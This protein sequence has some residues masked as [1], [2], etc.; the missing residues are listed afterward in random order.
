MRALP[1]WMAYLDTAAEA[2]FGALR[3]VDPTL[4]ELAAYD[5]CGRAGPALTSLPAPTHWK[6]LGLGEAH[7]GHTVG[8][9]LPEEAG[10]DLLA[11]ADSGSGSGG[12]GIATGSTGSTTGSV[13][14]TGAGANTTVTHRLSNGVHMPVLGL[15]TWQLDG[16]ACEEAV[17]E[18]IKLGYRHIDTAEAYGNEAQVGWAIRRAVD[19]GLV[20]REDLFVATK[21]SDEVH[22]GYEP[23]RALVKEQL[24]RLQV[25]YVD[26]YMLHSPL[27]SQES[28][29]THTSPQGGQPT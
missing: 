16:E 7:P 23:T 11:G 4:P 17:Y 29:V 14:G 19:E 8:D 1:R 10:R 2:T 9:T 12:T 15:G 6:H 22:A 24:E 5:P 25:A 27:S 18:A 26:L 28:E 3:T 21:L 13:T 20:T